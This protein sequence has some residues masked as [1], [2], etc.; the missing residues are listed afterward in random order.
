MGPSAAGQLPVR[1]PF[2]PRLTPHSSLICSPPGFPPQLS[3]FP[4]GLLRP[5][6]N[7]ASLQCL[8]SICSSTGNA[9]L[10]CLSPAVLQG[11]PTP[12]PPTRSHDPCLPARYRCLLCGFTLS[13]SSHGLVPLASSQN[14]S[15]LRVG[16]LLRLSLHCS[17]HLTY[18]RWPVS[19]HG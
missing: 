4:S 19:G 16:S 17:W 11:S 3:L 7:L 15:S 13:P 18:R 8:P 5:Q 2:L 12:P 9:L 6:T 10:L 1:R 14:L